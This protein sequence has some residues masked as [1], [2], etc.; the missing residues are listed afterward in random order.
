[1]SY[2]GP[3][4]PINPHK[5]K[6]DPKRI[7]FRSLWERQLFKWCDE[8]CFVK[9]W[10]SEEIVVPYRC[11]TDKQLHRY[12]PDVFIEFSD[13]RKLLIEVKPK[14][15]TVQPRVPKRKTKRFITEV[16]TY[17]KNT[18]KWAAAEAYAKERGWTFEIWS[19]DM[20]R[21][22]GIVIIGTYK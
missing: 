4:Q 20:L 21:K 18:S 16:L 1:M 7:V 19:E 13:G 22:L 12:F 8:H 15:E 6:G 14:K 17:V 3:F 2:H 5:Y 9:A 10:S 11:D